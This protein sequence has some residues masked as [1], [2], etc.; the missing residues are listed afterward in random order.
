MRL[1]NTLI[2]TLLALM[3]ILSVTAAVFL[4]V[5]GSLARLTG[6]YH[7]RPGMSLFPAEN[8]SRLN[9]VQWIRIQ[10]LHDSMECIRKE[11]GTWWIAHPFRDRMSPSAVQLILSFTAQA[12]LVDTL[13]LNHTTRASLREYGVETTPHTITLKVANGGDD[14]STIA[15]YTLGSASPWLADAEDGEHVLPT[16]YLRTDFYGRDKRIHVVRGNIL[17]IFKNGLEGLRDPHVLNYEQDDL[18]ALSIQRKGEKEILISRQTAE[19]PWAIFSPTI[20]DANQDNVDALLSQLSRIKAVRIDDAESVQLPEE[21]E[22]VLT[23][24]VANRKPVRLTLYPAF[25]SPSDGQRLCYATVED[26]PVVFTLAVEPRLRRKGSYAELVNHVLSLPVLPPAMIARIQSANDAVYVDDLTFNLKEL[27]S[28]RL[29]NIESKDI[30]K[31]HLRSRYAAQPVRL[32]RIP[33]DTEGQV[34]DVWMVSAAGQRYQEAD[35]NVV[36][37][38]L[39]S[40]SNVPVADFEWDFAPGDDVSDKIKEYGLNSP[41]YILLL[42]PRECAARAVLFGVDMPLVKDRSPRTFYFR[43]IRSAGQP[44]YWVAMEQNMHSIYRLSSRMT[45]LFAFTPEAWKK[46]NMVQFPISALRTLTL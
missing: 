35:P 19:T 22:M 45:K 9:E 24:T 5:D 8:M 32:L 1:R 27:R 16:T 18:L 15:R 2:T 46:R 34:G 23:F 43:R 39:N 17:S 33:G 3:A 31:V 25:T 12:K 28:T 37:D 13:P 10:D 6:W 20:C 26:R 29:S 7:F 21:P 14:L 41:D 11:D 36:A 38:F 40:L 44:P 42:Q 30:D 4:T